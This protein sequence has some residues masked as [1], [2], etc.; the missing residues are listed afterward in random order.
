M[1]VTNNPL[2]NE[3]ISSRDFVEGNSLDVLIRT[4]N[5][6]HKGWVLLTHPLYGNLR[7]HQHPYRSILMERASDS[8]SSVDPLSVEYIENAIAIYSAQSS[9]ILSVEGMPEDVRQDFAFI[10]ADLM[11][12]S[13]SRYRMFIREVS[14]N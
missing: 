2:L 4:R 13:L 5:L 12:E 3:Q 1:L 7:P 14:V 8:S 6:I 10:D 9:R 11:K